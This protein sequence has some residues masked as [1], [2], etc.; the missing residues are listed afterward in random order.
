MLRVIQWIS[1]VMCWFATGLNIYAMVRLNRTRKWYEEKNN[2]LN[3]KE[4]ELNAVEEY[5][6]AMIDACTEFLEATR[7]ESEV[8]EEVVNDRK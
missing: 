3:A 2:E 1:I 8:T 6:L 5:F 4:Y 7:K